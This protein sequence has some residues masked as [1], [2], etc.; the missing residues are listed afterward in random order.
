[1]SGYQSSPRSFWMIETSPV[2]S[3]TVGQVS[4]DV[5][6]SWKSKD[7]FH[8]KQGRSTC[9]TII[10]PESLPIYLKRHWQLPWPQRLQA[11]WR[12]ESGWS[13]AAIEWNNLH[14]ARDNGFLVPEPL[15]MGQ[16]VGP[17][18]NVQSFLAIRELSGMLPLHQA[19]PQAYGLLNESSFRRWKQKL[20]EIIGQTTRRLHQTGRA[21]QLFAQHTHG[22]KRKA[23]AL[24]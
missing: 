17:G 9:R 18:F 12:P 7:D 2:W 22:N 5:V 21:F 1:M 24:P 20:I 19:V 23:A 13:P 16:A 10:G 4:G 8:A 3:K 6:M 14:W 11:R 15:A